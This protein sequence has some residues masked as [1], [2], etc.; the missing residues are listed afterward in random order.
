MLTAQSS[1]VSV[2]T[3]HFPSATSCFLTLMELK[4]F[5]SYHNTECSTAPLGRHN[6]K[7]C[8]LAPSLFCRIK[9]PEIICTT[10]VDWQFGLEIAFILVEKTLLDKKKSLE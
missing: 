1:S 6:T 5:L 9:H 10:H 8:M 7:I 3:K 2:L 4:S